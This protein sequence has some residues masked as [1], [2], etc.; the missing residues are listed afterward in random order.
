M[1]T[2]EKVVT[3]VLFPVAILLAVI[4][5]VWEE[6]CRMYRDSELTSNWKTN[7]KKIKQIYFVELRK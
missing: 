2:Y 1:K 3:V 5:P 4:E 7:F 6:L